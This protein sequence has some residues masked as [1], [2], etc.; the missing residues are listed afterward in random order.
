MKRSTGRLMVRGVAGL[1]VAALAACGGGL[2]AA[3]LAIAMTGSGTTTGA[4]QHDLDCV[5]RANVSLQ[6][7]PAE[8]RL[9]ASSTVSWSVSFSADC[10]DVEGTLTLAG[11][12]ASDCRA[13]RR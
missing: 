5:K 8:I 2:A 3:R 1:L 7:A 11:R 4:G 13:A 10:S 6:A 12:E 9:G